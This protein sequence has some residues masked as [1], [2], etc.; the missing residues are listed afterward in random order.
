MDAG[1]VEHFDTLYITHAFDLS[2]ALIGHASRYQPHQPASRIKEADGYN[3]WEWF[4]E[5]INNSNQAPVVDFLSACKAAL[6]LLRNYILDNGWK[7]NYG[8]WVFNRERFPGGAEA[9]A[10]YV[11]SKGFVPGVWLAPTWETPELA[12]RNA[13]PNYGPTQGG[14]YTAAV[15]MDPS[16]LEFR[17]N[18]SDQVKALRA[19]GIRYFKTDFLSGSYWR[20]T[21]GEKFRDSKYPPER[22]LREFM[23]ELRMAMGDDAYWLACGTVI[24]PCAGLVD[25]ARIGADIKPKWDYL[26]GIVHRN[27]ARFW[28][29]NHLWDNDQDFLIIRGEKYS[30][31]G[32]I[33]PASE[34]IPARGFT[35]NEAETWCNYLVISGGPITWSDDPQEI[36]PEGIEIVRRTLLHGGGNAGIPLDLQTEELPTK[37]VRRESGHIY[38]GLFNWSEGSKTLRMTQAEVPELKQIMV[39]MDILHDRKFMIIHGTLELTLAPH[40]S[41]CLDTH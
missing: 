38:L 24:A 5:N 8:D 4:K 22:V 14:T 41:V 26:L 20:Y 9:W 19:S 18:V 16:V 29:H 28:M 7:Q 25:A 15:E 27:A 11:F 12:A 10:S 3:S 17:K 6:P 21:Q 36:T 39:A 23:I 30:K 1:E 34:D 35:G 32:F 33:R 31:R 37:W 2:D 40:S 13:F